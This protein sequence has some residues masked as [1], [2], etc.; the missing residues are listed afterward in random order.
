MPTD[1]PRTA[2]VTVPYDASTRPPRFFVEQLREPVLHHRVTAH[3]SREY[4][5]VPDSWTREQLEAAL[6]RLT[7]ARPDLRPQ[8]VAWQRESQLRDRVAE[9]EEQIAAARARYDLQE[10]RLSDIGDAIGAALQEAGLV[11]VQYASPTPSVKK[12]T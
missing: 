11:P 1:P 2:P 5:T 10:Q 6:L 3:P 12:G 7:D 9:L 4:M 8:T